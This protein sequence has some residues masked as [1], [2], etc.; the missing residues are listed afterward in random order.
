MPKIRTLRTKKAPKG[1]ELIEPILLELTQK[2]RDCKYSLTNLLSVKWSHGR[3]AQTRDRVGYL[4]IAP[5]AQSVHLQPVLQEALNFKRAV[6]ILSEREMGG[7]RT[8]CEVEEGRVRA[9]VLFTM[10]LEQRSHTW[11]R[12]HLQS[13]EGWS[14]IR[15]TDRMQ[16]VWLSRLCKWRLIVNISKSNSFISSCSFSL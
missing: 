14:L 10:H 1:W 16:D 6:W 13:A 7:C 3:E 5:S 4:Q 8:D 2:I 11:D 9:I 12:M 15:Q